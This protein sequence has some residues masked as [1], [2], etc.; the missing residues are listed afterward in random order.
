MKIF[1]LEHYIMNISKISEENRIYF[2]EYKLNISV[3][4]LIINKTIYNQW[5]YVQAE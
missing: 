1:D 2:L 5:Y 4:S 3:L